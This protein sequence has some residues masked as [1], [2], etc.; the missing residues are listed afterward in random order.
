MRK[1]I[2]LVLK[3]KTTLDVYFLDGRVKRYDILS[4]ADKYPQLNELNNQSLF[5]KGKLLGWSTVYW[6][7]Y[8]DVDVET[9][10]DEG[11]DVTNQYEDI[12]STIVGYIIK[13][14]RLEQNLS[15]EDLANKIGIDQSDLSK[16][17]KGLSNPSIKMINRIA[18]GLNSKLSISLL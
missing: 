8:L 6:N 18:K 11:E 10:Y 1:A 17:E 13:E 2:K 16:I 7:E 5:E 12:E 3:E 14:K 4:L 9:I 15:Q